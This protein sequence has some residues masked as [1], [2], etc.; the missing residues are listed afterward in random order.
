MIRQFIRPRTPARPRRLRPEIE[1]LEDRLVLDASTSGQWS[2]VINMPNA[3]VHALM[4]PNGKSVWY[5]DEN[6]NDET[7]VTLPTDPSSTT[8]TFASAAH[9][10]SYAFCSGSAMMADGRY[11]NAGGD[12]GLDTGNGTP[13]AYTLDT[14]ANAG[15][16]SWTQLPNMNEGRWYPSL[17]TLP[18]GN[19][20]VVSGNAFG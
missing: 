10:G 17:T 20:L 6:A 16:G 1:A 4:T 19:V 8:L 14:L 18:N 13:Y 3:M 2:S 15:V 5:W 9:R 7:V 12:Q 11:F